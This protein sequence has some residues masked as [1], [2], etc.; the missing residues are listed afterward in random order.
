[1]KR[2]IGFLL[3]LLSIAVHGQ[4][5][6]QSVYLKVRGRYAKDSETIWRNAYGSREKRIFR[7][8]VLDIKVKNTQQKRG[9]FT[10]EWFFFAKVLSG[11][12]RWIYDHGS[13]AFE[14]T[15]GQT[16]RFHK[17]SRPVESREEQYYT[18]YRNLWSTYKKGIKVKGYIVWIKGENGAVLQSS[19]SSRDLEELARRPQEVLGMIEELESEI[20]KSCVKV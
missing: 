8:M 12:R 6:Y 5:G 4:G 18:Y 15:G 10:M 13:E 11:K 3:L 1:M 2:S 19:A 20:R 7:S 16:V 14:L 17:L 9:R